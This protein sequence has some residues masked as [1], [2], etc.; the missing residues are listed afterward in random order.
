VTRFRWTAAVV[1][2]VVL[3]FGIALASGF[4]AHDAFGL[5][6]DDSAGVV[7][8]VLTV[9]VVVIA[10]LAAYFAVQSARAARESVKPLQ[11]TAD[12][13]LALADEAKREDRRRE[14]LDEIHM[15]RE[16]LRDISVM[17]ISQIAA[18]ATSIERRAQYFAAWPDFGGLFHAFP[19]VLPDTVAL[20]ANWPLEDFERAPTEPARDALL[21]LITQRVRELQDLRRDGA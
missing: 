1:G 14:L 15:L 13:L 12:R 10:T 11:D 3:T 7:T 20:V 9:L 17:T 16:M 18:S 4:V 5:T 19:H 2:V 8:A 21:A 6:P